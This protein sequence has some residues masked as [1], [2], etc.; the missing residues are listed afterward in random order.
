MGRKT[1][2]NSGRKTHPRLGP[3]LDGAKKT[4]KFSG[5]VNSSNFETRRW[6]WDPANYD[7]ISGE[8][9][10]TIERE[11]PYQLSEHAG[12]SLGWT[13]KPCIAR[14][15]TEARI[16]GIGRIELC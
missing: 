9:S 10:L 16:G 11:S 13:R 14:I 2:E 15:K 1:A 6:P 5:L 4:V 7:G 12:L 8:I 3:I